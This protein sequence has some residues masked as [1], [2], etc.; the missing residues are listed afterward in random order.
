MK[1]EI[2]IDITREHIHDAVVAYD[3]EYDIRELD[4]EEALKHILYEALD[5]DGNYSADVAIKGINPSHKRILIESFAVAYVEHIKQM[6]EERL[7]V[8]ID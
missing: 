2:E 4:E 6:T 8:S 7:G 5:L 1:V 3:S